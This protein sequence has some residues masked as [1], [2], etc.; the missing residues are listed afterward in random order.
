M[1]QK[2]NSGTNKMFLSSNKMTTFLHGIVSTTVCL[3]HN[4][5][6]PLS[7]CP[8]QVSSL[9]VY[10][11]KVYFSKVYFSKVYFTKVYFPKVYFPKIYFSNVYFSK[12]YF[13]KV[14]FQTECTR[15]SACL[16]SF[17][18]LVF[19]QSYHG[20]GMTM[21]IQMYKGTQIR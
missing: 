1:I 20:I 11:P 14:Y 7:N 12:V 10:F 4:L 19:L 5:L 17:C 13:R 3:Y 6:Q 2:A 8:N 9:K 15:S 18:E 21:L 16:P